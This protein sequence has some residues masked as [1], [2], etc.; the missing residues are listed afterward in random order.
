MFELGDRIV[1]LAVSDAKLVHGLYLENI[2]LM[3]LGFSYTE[4]E[5]L[6]LQERKIYLDLGKAYRDLQRYD[7]AS[8]A[9]QTLLLGNGFGDKKSKKRINALW[10]KAASKAVKELNIQYETTRLAESTPD[11]PVESRQEQKNSFRNKLA[12]FAANKKRYEEMPTTGRKLDVSPT[13]K[14]HFVGKKTAS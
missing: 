1:N 5:N 9:L 2:Q 13:I 14:N 8:L 10:K 11:S 6:S 3:A 12:Q 4:A 7:E